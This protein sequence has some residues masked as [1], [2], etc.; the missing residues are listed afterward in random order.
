MKKPARS[1]RRLQ[2]ED[3]ERREMMAVTAALNSAGTLNVTGTSYSDNLKFYQVGGV[4]TLSGVG[5]WTASSVKSIALNL[6]Q[7]NDSVSFT[8]VSSPTAQ[9]ILTDI[10]IK[11]SPGVDV[12][13]FD[14]HDVTLNGAGHMFH[15]SPGGVATLD[16]DF[17]QLESTGRP[18]FA[19]Y[20][21]AQP[22]PYAHS[23][24]DADTS[25]RSGAPS[26]GLYAQLV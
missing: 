5:G 12:A 16:G 6:G 4:L 23:V 26:T 18:G 14:G 20:T 1:S 10:T 7:G 24:G 21:D 13:H 19:F 9:R 3:L 11:S 17:A 25:T 2:Y 15:V 22:D 8:T